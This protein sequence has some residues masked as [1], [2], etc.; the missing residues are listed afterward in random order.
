MKGHKSSRSNTVLPSSYDARTVYPDS[1]S[2]NRVL[3]QGNCGSCWTFSATG[4]LADRLYRQNAGNTILSAQMV[5]DCN[6][7]CYSETTGFGDLCNGGCN[8][9]YIDLALQSFVTDGVKLVKESCHPYVGE[10][11]TC[12]TQCD[13]GSPLDYV[14]ATVTDVLYMTDER[15][16]MEEIYLHGSIAASFTI[17]TDF[18]YYASGI[19]YHLVG[20]ALGGHAIKLVGYGEERGVKYWIAQNSWGPSWGEN[21]YFRIARG[22]DNCGIEAD[23]WAPYIDV[24]PDP[25]PTQCVW[26]GHVGRVTPISEQNHTVVLCN[27]VAYDVCLLNNPS[28]QDTI[29]YYQLSGIYQAGATDE[30]LF[31]ASALYC[32]LAFPKYQAGSVLPPCRSV[33]QRYS[34]LCASSTVYCD[35]FPDIPGVNCNEL[36]EIH[37]SEYAAQCPRTCTRTADF[38]SSSVCRGRL[39][40]SHA[41]SIDAA[42]AD[43][44][45]LHIVGGASGQ[46]REAMLNWACSL[47]YPMCIAQTREIFDGCRSTCIDAHRICET[48]A[49]TC[50]YYSGT[51]GKTNCSGTAPLPVPTPTPRPTPSRLPTPLPTPSHTTAPPLPTPTPK[52]TVL[53]ALLVGIPG[54]I[55]AIVALG[56]TAVGGLVGGWLVYCCMARRAARTSLP[57]AM[58]D[59]GDVGL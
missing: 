15:M 32:G 43:R 45:A 53:P 56:M 19:Y 31:A 29:A 24:V 49:D 4:A 47:A 27:Q 59:V 40:Y 7:N 20:E 2:L 36:G 12:P 42:N 17:Y 28:V 44:L 39:P 37:F 18:M 57:H 25:A 41:C 9:G 26:N 35:G 54:W 55:A 11:L 51:Y 22:V 33:C 6:Q 8:G 23:A 21:G 16:M 38:P 3:D 46:C 13:D 14:H 1:I 50:Y 30:C 58:L 48:R 34:S 52:Q 10:D 5:V